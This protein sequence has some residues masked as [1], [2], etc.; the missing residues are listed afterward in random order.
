M[1]TTRESKLV[2]AVTEGGWRCVCVSSAVCLERVSRS[3]ESTCGLS[4]AIWY[5]KKLCGKGLM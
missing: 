5:T 2:G 1:R 3:I 4:F